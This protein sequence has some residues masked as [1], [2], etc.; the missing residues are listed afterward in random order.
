M[1]DRHRPGDIVSRRKGPLR[2]K[3]IVMGDGRILHNTPLRGEHVVDEIEF[4]AGRR[5]RVEQRNERFGYSTRAHAEPFRAQ[6]YNLFTNNCEH[7]VH[8]ATT[9]RAHSPQLKA[10]M[11]GLTVGAAVFALTRHPG[12]AAA[13]YAL[14]RAIIARRRGR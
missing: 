12:A 11:A 5:V 7:T 4:S 6:R 10:W 8:R 14:G 1:A 3:G 13:A 2:H 9:G